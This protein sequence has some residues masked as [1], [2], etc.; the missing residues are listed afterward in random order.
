MDTNSADNEAWMDE[1]PEEE[2]DWAAMM[3]SRQ[4]VAL[5]S[6]LQLDAILPEL[7]SLSRPKS[8]RRQDEF[9][10]SSV[11]M[12][13]RNG[14]S[15]EML[16]RHNEAAFPSRG[17][18]FALHWAFPQA[19][20]SAFAIATA[21][22]KARGSNEASHAAV[23]R[24]VGE[25][26]KAKKYPKTMSF[27]ALGGLPEILYLN[28]A[29]HPAACTLAFSRHDPDTVDTQIAQ[30]LCSTRSQ[31]LRS[32]KPKMKLK[33]KAGKPK[34]S[35]TREDWDRVS[36]RLGP[37]SILSLLYRNRIR[38]NYGEIDTYLS[39]DLDTDAVFHALVHIVHC[40]NL[41]HE[42]H[43]C[44]VVG[45]EVYEQL[46]STAKASDHVF[47]ADRRKSVKSAFLATAGK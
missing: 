18:A 25:D 26:M 20:Y 12:W 43:L 41:V 21:F 38:A 10:A 40:L 14:W 8:H 17:R 5:E 3:T 22:F 39:E 1:M 24:R 7:A 33:T 42:A 45:P 32:Y 4:F 35:F 9:D 37:T 36:E 27:L 6:K 28:I 31:D 16:L 30:F 2:P 46:S 29:K 11:V 44:S 15:T 34:K 23:I 19:Y 13:L 47:L